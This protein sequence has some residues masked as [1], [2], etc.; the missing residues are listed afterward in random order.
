MPVKLMNNLIRET[1]ITPCRILLP[2]TDDLTAWACVA[3]DQFTGKKEY[4]KR[5]E[6]FVGDKKS[7]LKLVLPEAYLN[8]DADERIKSANRNIEEYLK[9]G[10]FKELPE[11]FILTVR[12]TPYVK[13]RIGLIG[14]VDLEKYDFS[15]GSRTLVRA[16]EGTIEERIPPRL[17]IRRNAAA[18]FSHIMIL[19]DDER[20]EITEEL[21][22]NRSK[23]KKL[24]DFELNMGGGSVEG[25]FVE[26]YKAVSEAFSK[27][28]DKERL[29]KKY[30][31]EDEFIFAVGDGNHSLATAKAFW[32]EIKTG[33]TEEEKKTH[34]A[35]FA[36]AEFVNVYD[37]GIY[38]EP[39]YRFVDGVNAEKLADGLKD[40]TDARF[41]VYRGGKES[42]YG[43]V[44]NVP[45]A[46]KAVDEYVKNYIA[47]HGGRVDYIHG[48]EE[49]KKMADADDSSVAILFSAINKSDLFRYVSENGAF[50]RKT[51]SMGEGEEK[52]YYLEGK[53]I[54]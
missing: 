39:I 15:K 30:G 45:E 18:E 12:K 50:P 5:L 28:S 31:K 32:N 40:V 44:S 26:D 52:R 13:R 25:Y 8:D 33:L 34:P 2:K 9:E 16:T 21:Y 17:K 54:K 35:R 24:Y 11:G 47:A 10:V 29:I 7:A 20:C 42:F 3:C 4:W 1:G 14:A 22:E 51:F 19:F 43:S 36:L 38:F 41:S 46:I 49:V 27:L 23:L 53:R 6:Q 48:E 37:E